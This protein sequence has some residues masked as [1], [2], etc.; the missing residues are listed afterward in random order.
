VSPEPEAL[1]GGFGRILEALAAARA[2]HFKIGKDALGLLRP[3]KIVAYFPGFDALARA[4]ASIAGLLDGTPAQGVPFT[5][6][7]AGDGLLSW[8]I[9]PPAEERSAWGGRE[10]WRFWLTHRLARALLAG[11]SAGEEGVEPW[12]FALERLRLEGVDTDTWTP[13]ARLFRES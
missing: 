3:D 13:G 4:A 11:R 12:R 9:D 5:A 6:P 8:G 7:V 2:P 1:A 10:S